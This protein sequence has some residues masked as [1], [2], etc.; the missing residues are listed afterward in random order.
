MTNRSKSEQAAIQVALSQL[1]A[2]GEGFPASA[3]VTLREAKA[4]GFS[5][6]ARLRDDALLVRIDPLLKWLSTLD[7]KTVLALVNS[8][9]IVGWFEGDGYEPENEDEDGDFNY[10]LSPSVTEDPSHPAEDYDWA[11]SYCAR[12]GFLSVAVS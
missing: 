6:G 10:L 1:N 2:F 9:L 3:L 11:F 7:G 12:D 8:E 4:L 5:K